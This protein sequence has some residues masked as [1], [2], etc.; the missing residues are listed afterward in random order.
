[1]KAF[2]T[3]LILLI[4]FIKYGQ[5]TY[6][7]DDY[8]EN[9][10]ESNGMGNGVNNDNYVLTENIS[11]VLELN[12]IPS[13]NISNLIG[14]EDFDSL[15]ELFIINSNITFLDMSGNEHLERLY[16]QQ[17]SLDSINIE[18]NLNLTN[19][20]VR[21]N[22]LSELNVSNNINLKSLSFSS[23]NITNID[24]TNN[25]LLEYLYCANSQLVSLDISQNINLID[26]EI[27]W[28]ENLYC[29]DVFDSINFTNNFIYS[30]NQFGWPTLFDST[31]SFSNNCNL[32]SGCLDT[33]ANNYN[34][35]ATIN[36]YDC[37][38]SSW[39]CNNNYACI[40][41]SDNSGSFLT[42]QECENNCEGS[43]MIIGQWFTDIGDF[44]EITSDSLIVYI[45]DQTDQDCY[46]KELYEITI[47][48]EQNSFT[49]FSENGDTTN[50]NYFNFS[51]GNALAFSIILY[52][53]TINLISTSFNPSNWIECDSTDCFD[54]NET[55]ISIFGDF[56]IN[57]CQSLID[58]L[59][60][61]YNYNLEESCNW[62]GGL[63]FDLDSNII[64][65][66]CECTCEE[67]VQITTWECFAGSCYELDNGT[68]EYNSLQDCELSCITED[69]TWKCSSGNCTEV[70][71]LSG[72]FQ[73]IEECEANCSTIEPTFNCI[74]PLNNGDG[75]CDEVLDGT[76]EF[77]TLN[78]CEQECQ[79]VSSI[80]E[81]LIR[82]NIYPNPSSNIFNLEFNS[83]SDTEILVT[84]V[85]GV[86]VYFESLQSADEYKTKIDLS[87]YSKGIY[88]LTIKKS[89]VISNHKL[90]L[91]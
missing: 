59:S 89:D 68:G 77:L 44:I 31:T 72:E 62:D 76:G 83:N 13:G 38:Y 14:I 22:N 54:D 29:V 25:V 63:M 30:E 42:L 52:N 7:P 4:P 47:D 32:Y 84:N 88:N 73:T 40:E 86:K 78:E 43:D 66:I 15:I 85:L 39:E 23:N 61:N 34:E 75:Y 2:Y 79:N 91:Q 20:T 19:L 5:Q 12:I 51:S 3:L 48:S 81:I 46:E 16:V 28:N 55:I 64:M 27:Y 80:S 8:F 37:E 60:F 24:L 49:L 65:N 1:M 87:N 11:S 35:Y 18:Y 70:F 9:Y 17:N 36:N 45:F 53:D 26:F 50:I 90:I 21:D 58:Y 69:T 6:V 82:I 33:L 41:L 71:D 10:L 56:F 74:F 67:D 57:D